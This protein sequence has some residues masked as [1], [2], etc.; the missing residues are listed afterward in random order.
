MGGKHEVKPPPSSTC[1]LFSIPPNVPFPPP[2]SLYPTCTVAVFSKKFFARGFI[3]RISAGTH[4]SPMR[5]KVLKA[6]PWAG[7]VEGFRREQATWQWS[8]TLKQRNLVS[9]CPIHE[10]TPS[11]EGEG[12][13]GSVL[14]RIRQMH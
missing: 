10:A 4:T 11:H 8:T 9:L 6:R 2:P 12:V 7:R 3:S 14:S 1:L 5:G 13:E